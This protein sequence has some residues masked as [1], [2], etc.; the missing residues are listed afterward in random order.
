MTVLGISLT[1]A[2]H[3]DSFP[4]QKESLFIACGVLPVLTSYLITPVAKTSTA[5]SYWSPAGQRELF[6]AWKLDGGCCTPSQCAETWEPC[7][8]TTMNVT[9][10]LKAQGP[11]LS[12]GLHASIP[13]SYSKG[14][15]YCTQGPRL[16]AGL[17]AT[18]GLMCFGYDP[19]WLLFISHKLHVQLSQF[20]R[21]LEGFEQ[22]W[23]Q[24]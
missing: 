22:A 6:C 15:Q 4:Y 19:D 13:V 16:H 14:R 24:A 1:F 11:R 18:L 5:P 7:V 23:L 17:T 8:S 3:S 9:E 21:G 12:A 10:G 20:A 2:L